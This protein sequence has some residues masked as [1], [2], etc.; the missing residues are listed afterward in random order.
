MSESAVVYKSAAADTCIYPI[1][2]PA[3]KRGLLPVEIYKS[4]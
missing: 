1:L 4:C 2:R 3:L